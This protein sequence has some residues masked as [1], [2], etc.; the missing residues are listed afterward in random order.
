MASNDNIRFPLD[1]INFDNTFNKNDD[2]LLDLLKSQNV[3]PFM[4]TEWIRQ[5]AEEDGNTIINNPTNLYV[6]FV[7]KMF[8][9]WR[10]V[11]NRMTDER[12]AQ[13]VNTERFKIFCEW[14][15]IHI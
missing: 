15:N 13:E 12:F 5:C 14:N 2:E 1:L 8:N 6:M 4:M 7:K 11:W 3:K 9:V 10:N